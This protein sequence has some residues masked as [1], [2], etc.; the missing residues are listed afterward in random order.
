MSHIHT[1]LMSHKN[2]LMAPELIKRKYLFFFKMCCTKADTPSCMFILSPRL[3]PVP[4][5]LTEERL[6]TDLRGRELHPGTTPR[7][8]LHF[9]MSWLY[10]GFGVKN[11][12][13]LGSALKG[14]CLPVSTKQRQESQDTLM[15]NPLRMCIRNPFRWKV[16]L[17]GRCVTVKACHLR[18]PSYSVSFQKNITKGSLSVGLPGL[19]TTSPMV[20]TVL[21]LQN[22]RQPL[23]THLSARKRHRKGQKSLFFVC[24]LH[25]EAD[26]EHSMDHSC[27]CVAGGRF[28][29]CLVWF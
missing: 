9:H 16:F 29:V 1:Q 21:V 19:K 4:G 27:P 12:S 28:F 5:W 11:K 6:P 17:K 23:H 15:R 13:S 24:S 26:K 25:S 7:L 3:S 14:Q 2:T 8:D 10:G 20:D 22:L 18:E